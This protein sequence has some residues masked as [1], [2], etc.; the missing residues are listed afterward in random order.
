MVSQE[1]EEA[2]LHE[3]DC[4]SEYHRVNIFLL[5]VE[6]RIRDKLAC[7]LVLSFKLCLESRQ[8]ASLF[9]VSLRIRLE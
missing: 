9:G 3:S 7:I 5:Q 6:A 1:G 4:L 8:K 2:L